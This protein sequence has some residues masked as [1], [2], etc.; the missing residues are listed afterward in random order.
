MSETSVGIFFLHALYCP[1]LH[2]HPICV[3]TIAHV[4]NRRLHNSVLCVF[5]HQ[6]IQSAGFLSP[7]STN[8]APL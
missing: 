8:E 3:Q 1:V 7:P 2:Y 5:D 6:S 4:I